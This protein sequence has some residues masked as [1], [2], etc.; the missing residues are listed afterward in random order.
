LQKSTA[1]GGSV[2]AS[3]RQP[4]DIPGWLIGGG[5][6]FVLALPVALIFPTEEAWLEGYLVYT[7]VIMLLSIPIALFMRG[8]Q[9]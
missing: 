8:K 7:A 9:P 5:A 6:A 1:A 2:E 3:Q 4:P